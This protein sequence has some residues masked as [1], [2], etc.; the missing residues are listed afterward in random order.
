VSVREIKGSGAAATGSEDTAD[1]STNNEDPET[2]AVDAS[3]T[4]EEASM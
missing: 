4:N 3:S 1:A 2:D